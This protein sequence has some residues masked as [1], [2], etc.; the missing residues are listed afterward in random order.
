MSAPEQERAWLLLRPHGGCLGV[1][2]ASEAATEE[3]AWMAFYGGAQYV[4]EAK[5][6]GNRVELVSRDRVPQQFLYLLDDGGAL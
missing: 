5:G 1:V 3:Q 4:A 2:P 6:R